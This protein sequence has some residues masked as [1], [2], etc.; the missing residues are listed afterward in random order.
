MTNGNKATTQSYLDNRVN[1]D[2]ANY[3]TDYASYLSDSTHNGMRV[4]VV[5]VIYPASSTASPVVGYAKFFLLTSLNGTAGG[6]STFYKSVNGNQPYCAAYI[7]TANGTTTG[8]SATGFTRVRLM[9]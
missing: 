9:Q 7:G 5:P 8:A 1:M 6:T 3:E 2:P 4:I